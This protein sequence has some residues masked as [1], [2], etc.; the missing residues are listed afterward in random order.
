MEA[1]C[2]NGACPRLLIRRVPRCW[3]LLISNRFS[4]ARRDHFHRR[5]VLPKVSRLRQ[6]RCHGHRSVAWNGQQQPRP[7]CVCEPS[8]GSADRASRRCCSTASNSLTSRLISCP[9]IAAPSVS[10]TLCRASSRNCF[11]R[12]SPSRPRLHFRNRA[13][14]LFLRQRTDL[15][16]LR[17]R[18]Q[19]PKATVDRQF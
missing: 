6:D 8:S 9:S 16:R 5:I 2:R 3:P 11:A 12:C 13:A 14:Q 17:S 10:P 1:I 18:G 7:R 19:Q 15:A 4:P